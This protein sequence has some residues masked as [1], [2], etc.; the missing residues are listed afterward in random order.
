ML[1]AYVLFQGNFNGQ[2]SHGKSVAWDIN[3]FS[4]YKCSLYWSGFLGLEFSL[5]SVLQPDLL[6]SAF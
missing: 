3:S 2:H 4:D 6:G 5:F 1:E